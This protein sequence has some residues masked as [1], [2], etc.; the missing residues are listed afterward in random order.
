MLR[1]CWINPSDNAFIFNDF[2]QDIAGHDSLWTVS[3]VEVS[4][5]RES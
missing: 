2:S 1:G 5:C 3:Q 4:S